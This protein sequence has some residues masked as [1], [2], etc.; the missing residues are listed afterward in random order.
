METKHWL[1]TLLDESNQTVGIQLL[2]SLKAD[3]A[4]TA[5]ASIIAGAHRGSYAEFGSQEAAQVVSFLLDKHGLIGAAETPIAL[6]EDGFTQMK[7]TIWIH[8]SHFKTADKV[9]A[10][11]QE[12][13]EFLICA[14]F[15]Y[16]EFGHGEIIDKGFLTDYSETRYPERRS[17]LEPDEFFHKEFPPLDETILKSKG[18]G[19]NTTISGIDFSRLP[20]INLINIP[21]E[22][23]DW[24]I[25]ML[26]ANG[27]I[28]S[29]SVLKGMPKEAANGWLT[30][31]MGSGVKWTMSELGTKEAIEIVDFVLKKNG[32]EGKANF[33]I[34]PVNKDGIKDKF[35]VMA[36]I[37][38]DS[39]PQAVAAAVNEGHLNMVAIMTPQ[40]LRG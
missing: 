19:L 32:V 22:V 6:P 3:E 5:S 20:K 38:D 10:I 1:V 37:A 8:A 13:E 12:A 39:N 27:Q 16:D 40:S 15:K 25:K 35:I 26:D 2:K 29:I 31:M 24:L 23:A 30:N 18:F 36:T 14:A 7:Y 17:Y 9:H 4:F 11:V 33:T 34:G 28:V 21:L